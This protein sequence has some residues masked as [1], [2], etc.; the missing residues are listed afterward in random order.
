MYL[1][2]SVLAF[3]SF[4]FFSVVNAQ[5]PPGDSCVCEVVNTVH[6]TS[7]TGDCTCRDPGN[8]S[9]V[10]P[11]TVGTP[12]YPDGAPEPGVC[13]ECDEGTPSACTFKPVEV[14]VTIA[15]CARECT[16]HKAGDPGV[17]WK[18][19]YGTGWSNLPTSGS[20]NF[21]STQAYTMP[22]PNAPNSSLCGSGPFESTVVFY[23]KNGTM[24]LKLTFEFACGKC[25][26]AT[27]E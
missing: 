23:K 7:G 25:P 26:A 1:I 9:Q 8:G 12:V 4:A 16:G 15:I 18:R 14:S 5:D 20:Q 19:A 27:A 21:N 24:A 10:D 11:F 13:V 22:P 17:P 6:V 3:T 2:P